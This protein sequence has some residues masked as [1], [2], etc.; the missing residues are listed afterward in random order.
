MPNADLLPLLQN[1]TVLPII[2][3]MS[4]IDP[5]PADTSITSNPSG[6]S[7]DDSE[8]SDK[9]DVCGES[10]PIYL[11]P[12]R[13]GIIHVLA[14]LAL[15]AILI[16]PNTLAH[17][18][19]KNTPI[20]NVPPGARF[21]WAGPQINL[22]LCR[23]ASL[24][25]LGVLIVCWFRRIPGQLQPGH[26][27]LLLQSIAMLFGFLLEKTSPLWFG[28]VSDTIKL[29]SMIKLQSIL[30]G[31][32]IFLVVV[33]YVLLIL[34]LRE[35]ISWKALFAS[36]AVMFAASGLFYFDHG[37][38]IWMHYSFSGITLALSSVVLFVLVVIL[39]LDR[40]NYPIRDWLH[41]LGLFL[42]GYQLA[43]SIFQTVSYLGP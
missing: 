39:A 18:Y 37:M 2:R 10:S 30:T 16:L 12:P 32:L 28:N 22:N 34:L 27:V 29:H 21:V 8:P 31:Y 17:Y 20:P 38:Q 33:A 25:G 42:I 5:H 9:G 23:A 43:L 35:A 1:K 11:R 7:P 24:V 15:A 41:W 13:L 26:W 14:F 3:V 36:L 19:G 4:D 6:E 40:S